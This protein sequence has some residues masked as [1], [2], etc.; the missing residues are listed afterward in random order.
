MRMKL[1]T[2]KSKNLM[3]V[4]TDT[5]ERTS[6]VLDADHFQIADFRVNVE[7]KMIQV[8]IVFGGYDSTGKWHTDPRQSAG[9]ISISG[10][11]PEQIANYNAL[12]LDKAGNP[13]C[14]YDEAWFRRLFVDCGM[15]QL[16]NDRIWGHESCEI[17]IDGRSAFK[18]E[19]PKVDEKV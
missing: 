16:L 19:K 10:E 7:A 12:A 18:K 15:L 13:H 1:T 14:C 6:E 8:A 5:V 2:D 9:S 4:V 11:R 17:H 3:A